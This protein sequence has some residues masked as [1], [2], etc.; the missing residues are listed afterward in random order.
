[1]LCLL[2]SYNQHATTHDTPGQ[3]HETSQ[4]NTEGAR[5]PGPATEAHLRSSTPYTAAT[6]DRAQ[7]HILLPDGSSS[8]N[9]QS[10]P[11]PITGHV[12]RTPALRSLSEIKTAQW[13]TTI[14][15]HLTT[16][17][18]TFPDGA[19]DIRFYVQPVTF[20]GGSKG[21]GLF[22]ARKFRKNEFLTIYIGQP[23]DR[24][25]HY[26]RRLAGAGD[27]VMEIP[28][29]LTDGAVGGSGSEL[30]NSALH[31]RGIHE[32]AKFS[33][34]TGSVKALRDIDVG[35]EICMSYF[36]GYWAGVRAM[37]RRRASELADAGTAGNG[38]GSGPRPPPPASGGE[39]VGSHS[40]GHVFLN[41]PPECS[42]T[43]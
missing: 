31:R 3:D 13:L 40:G 27:H 32:N 34:T 30:I 38:T 28:G 1:M 10:L 22:A 26:R 42:S 33:P 5:Q 23:I 21:S 14:S 39:E 25:E 2:S 18:A 24:E 35:Q 36:S 43:T 11:N 15:P 17:Q 8:D 37:D 20:P 41:T 6:T 4:R 16:I 7:Q 12:G 19:V 29:V 9:L